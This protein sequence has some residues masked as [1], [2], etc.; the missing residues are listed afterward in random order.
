MERIH[1]VTVEIY[2]LP[3]TISAMLLSLVLDIVS[4]VE[5]RK[6]YNALQRYQYHIWMYYIIAVISWVFIGG[7][8][9]D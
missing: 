2:P 8:C 3:N 9:G 1:A 4:F 5:P 6:I 7:F